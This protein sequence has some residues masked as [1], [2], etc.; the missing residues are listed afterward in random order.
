MPIYEHA[1][2][3]KL[4][5]DENGIILTLT[6]RYLKF[7]RVI[8]IYQILTSSFS[9]VSEGKACGWVLFAALACE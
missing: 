4:K 1:Y 3:W 2:Y 8:V 9:W 5:V 6:H 7:K